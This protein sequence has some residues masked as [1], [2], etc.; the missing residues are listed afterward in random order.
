MP[1]QKGN[2]ANPSGRPK[3]TQEQK[4]FE[5][6]C[7]QYLKE[8]GFEQ[9]K[10]LAQGGDRRWKMWALEIMLDRGF[11]KAVATIDANV[12]TE[13]VGSSLAEVASEL[14]R[15]ADGAATRSN[16]PAGDT[17]SSNKP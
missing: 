6:K 4:D 10:G 3:K 2:C 15:I 5:E 12:N 7:R 17:G 8:W 9:I 11:G 14:S 1:F 13:G 16:G